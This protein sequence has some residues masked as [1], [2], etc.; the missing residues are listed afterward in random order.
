MN[1]Q[2]ASAQ[3]EQALRDHFEEIL[4]LEIDPW[5]NTI[6][7]LVEEKDLQ[8]EF[9]LPDY[10]ALNV[11]KRAK[12]IELLETDTLRSKYVLLETS[13][14]LNEMCQK[15]KYKVIWEGYDRLLYQV[16]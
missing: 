13:S 6:C 11:C 8:W 10:I 1:E 3:Q 4:P 14:D 5:D 12:M 16:R 7:K 15:K 2:T 9:M